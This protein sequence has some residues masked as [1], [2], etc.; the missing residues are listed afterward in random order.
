MTTPTWLSEATS[1]TKV[2]FVPKKERSA[3]ITRRS[4]TP[5][6]ICKTRLQGGASVAMN[7]RVPPQLLERLKA[8]TD[9]HHS[10]VAWVLI[11]EALEQLEQNHEQ[12]T[13]EVA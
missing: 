1:T 6:I 13:V 4:G 7:M 8:L 5:K 3:T 11:E 12:W 2:A 9:G 10:V